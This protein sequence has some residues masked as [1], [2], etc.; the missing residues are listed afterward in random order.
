VQSVGDK[1]LSVYDHTAPSVVS[2]E[3][4]E[5]RSIGWNMQKP[6]AGAGLN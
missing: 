6:I 3:A 1:A 2:P 4:R 5:V